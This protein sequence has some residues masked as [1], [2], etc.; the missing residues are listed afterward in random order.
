M[1]LDEEDKYIQCI[2]ANCDITMAAAARSATDMAT[3]EGTLVEWEVDK[4][5][6]SDPIGEQHAP[7]G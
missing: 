4:L 1:T 3:S 6:L 2:L 7:V 5:I